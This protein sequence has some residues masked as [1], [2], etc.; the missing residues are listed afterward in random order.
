M[1]SVVRIWCVDTNGRYRIYQ[2]PL[3]DR[4]A[5]WVVGDIGGK[6]DCVMVVLTP[7]DEGQLMTA[8]VWRG[9]Q[10]MRFYGIE[11]GRVGDRQAVVFGLK[12]AAYNPGHHFR[13]KIARLDEC[14]A[15]RLPDC[16]HCGAAVVDLEGERSH[17][18]P[19]CEQWLTDEEL[20]VN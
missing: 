13:I 9:G 5:N 4:E 20:R 7:E 10:R 3:V 18:E 14:D 15:K 19:P 11:A 6:I 8:L 17:E 1:G 12:D 2:L 16:Q